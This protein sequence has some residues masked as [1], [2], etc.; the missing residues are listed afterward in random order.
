MGFEKLAGEACNTNRPL[1]HPQC[2][3]RHATLP[4]TDRR[5]FG[6]RVRPHGGLGETPKAR[7]LPPNL[8]HPQ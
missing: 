2:K 7:I 5:G 4:E 6:G 8:A 1:R 3:A